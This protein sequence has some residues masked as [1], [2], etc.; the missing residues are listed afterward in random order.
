M[1]DKSRTVHRFLF[2]IGLVVAGEAVFALPF[3]VARFFRPTVLEVFAMTNTELGAAQGIYGILAMLAYFPGGLL[4]DRFPA[5][6][7]LAFSL[8]MTAAGGLYMATFPGYR[9]ALILWGFFG[10]STILLFW[11]ALIRATRDWGGN[12]DQG[13]AFGLLDSGR[14]LL[15]AVLASIAVV[16]FGFFFPDSFMA[17]LIPV[18]MFHVIFLKSAAIMSL[19]R[20]KRKAR[21]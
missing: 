20:W 5:R 12:D 1:F 10:V 21:P 15:A 19:K 14:G 6:K 7:L 18:W 3:H 16:V 8:W 9:G 11:A 13:R 4:A 17:R 2:M